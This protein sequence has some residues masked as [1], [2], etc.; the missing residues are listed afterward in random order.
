MEINESAKWIKRIFVLI[1]FPVVIG[2]ILLTLS[3]IEEV[4]YLNSDSTSSFDWSCVS[5]NIP[6]ETEVLAALGDI[7]PGDEFV[8]QNVVVISLPD[9]ELPS[10]YIL[11]QDLPALSGHKATQRIT[12]N[13]PINWFF[14][15][16][17]ISKAVKSDK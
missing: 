12:H 1:C 13:S 7:E 9:N 17:P 2:S 10:H 5:T 15:D 6:F 14:T 8:D 4:S 11:P 16:V 3:L